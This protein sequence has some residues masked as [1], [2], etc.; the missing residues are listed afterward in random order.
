MD[1]GNTVTDVERRLERVFLPISKQYDLDEENARKLM[2]EL[3]EGNFLRRERC[4][5]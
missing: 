1:I 3:A 5:S 2:R 4:S